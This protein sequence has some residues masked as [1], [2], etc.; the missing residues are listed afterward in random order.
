M[1]WAEH[2][3]CRED[4][5]GVHRVLVERPDGQRA[6]GW[7]DDMKWDGEALTELLWISIRVSGRTCD[8]L[9]SLGFC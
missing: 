2:V 1:R 4:R 3:A 7:D 9:M 5:R 6:L 8:A